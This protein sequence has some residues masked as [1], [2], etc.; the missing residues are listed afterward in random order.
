MGH[1]IRLLSWH[2]ASAPSFILYYQDQFPLISM[3]S[4]RA[5][6]NASSD[7]SFGF[8]QDPL[9]GTQSLP[10]SDKAMG[11]TSRYWSRVRSPWHFVEKK[12]MPFV[13]IPAICP[14]VLQPIKMPSPWII[15]D[16]AFTAFG[17]RWSRTGIP[18]SRKVSDLSGGH[19]L[20]RLASFSGQV[21]GAFASKQ[22]SICFTG[23]REKALP[24]EG[25]LGEC[26]VPNG[27]RHSGSVLRI[28]RAHRESRNLLRQG[29]SRPHF[30]GVFNPTFRTLHI[31]KPRHYLMDLSP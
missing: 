7:Q 29:C 1:P 12:E 8:L 13:R 23:Q 21:S 15:H 4:S 16:V 27:L 26:K 19:A 30:P 24:S 6:V 9:T 20:T 31:L 17:S 3:Y 5:C 2:T 18:S 28:L 10:R 22:R 14:K 11:G 25:K